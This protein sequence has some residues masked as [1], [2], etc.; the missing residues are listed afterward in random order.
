MNFNNMTPEKCCETQDLQI[1][2][3]I[4]WDNWIYKC[5]N[6]G[7]KFLK[8]HHFYHHIDENTVISTIILT[9]DEENKFK[10]VLGVGNVG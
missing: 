6:C 5:R 9:D 4:N 8:R 3:M 2:E 7:E 1:I 10:I